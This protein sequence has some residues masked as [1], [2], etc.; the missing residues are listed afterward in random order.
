[1]I[2]RYIYIYSKAFSHSSRLHH[3]QFLCLEEITIDEG[4]PDYDD[5]GC[6]DDIIKGRKYAAWRT[7]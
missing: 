6:L 4:D 2:D 5:A 1:M 3:I 7:A